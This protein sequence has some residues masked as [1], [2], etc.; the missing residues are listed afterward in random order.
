M[1]R[2]HIGSRKGL[3]TLARGARGWEVEALS[4][5]GVQVT[6][7]APD[8]RD[9]AL[10]AAVGHGHFGAKLHRSTDGGRTFVERT[11][12]TYPPKPADLD[13]RDPM[14][15]LPVPWNVELIWSLEA[16]GVPGEIW[17]GTIPGGLFRS[18]DGADSWS[19]VEPLWL[20]PD[21][22]RWMGGGYDFAGIHSIM[23][24]PRDPRRVVVGVSCGGVWATHDGGAT[25]SVRGTGQVA[26]YMPPEQVG[27]LV[28]QD[29]HRIVRC[30]AAP[31][32]MWMQHHAGVF[33]SDDA[34]MTFRVVD[35]VPPST[36]GFAVAVHPTQPDT[37]WFVPAAADSQR[38]PVD[39]KV[40][41]ARTRD[42]GR[43][44]AVLDAGLPQRHAYD[45]VYR[46][47]LDISADGGVLAFG[48][49]SGGLWVSE[50]Q[51]D[52]WT[53][54]DARLPPIVCVRFA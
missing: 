4:F 31:D 22:K 9:G 11:A 12:P 52:H 19:L 47:G 20:H 30:P 32:R 50:D 35:N 54:V 25:W 42:G 29:P 41:V 1:T 44:F 24:D 23:P 28:A 33:V 51:G 34:G 43:S 2:L 36:F 21:R 17:C 15:Q 46:H 3:F 27:D 13:D 16:G 48:S 37:A 14:R 8:R 39:G 5:A 10:Y 7:I 53:A 18:T 45:L 26:S 40:V 6:A 38:M 49:T